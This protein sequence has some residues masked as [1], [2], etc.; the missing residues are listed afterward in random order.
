MTKSL[1]TLL[2]QVIQML[3]TLSLSPGVTLQCWQDHR[4]KQGCISI[5]LVR[6][7]AAEEA[8]MN[9]LLPAVL[10]RGSRNHPDLRS[11][12]FALDDLYGA[13]VSP[14]V[15]RVG[16]RQTTGLFCAFMDQ[17][18][19]LPGDRVL[20]PMAAFLNELL[21][22]P[23]LDNGGFTPDYVESEKKNLISAIEA[24][25]N[26][27]QAYAM[28][29]L[30]K[31]MG[32]A[33][34]FG[35][36]RLGEPAEI[37]AIEPKE[38]YHHYQKILSESPIHLFYAGSAQPEAVAAM[39]GSLFD[40]LDRHPTPLLPQTD[41]HSSESSHTVEALEVTQGKL[42]LGYTTPITNRCPEFAAMQVFNSLFGAGMT[43]KLFL[44]LREEQSL[45]YSIGSGYYSAKGILTVYAGIDQDREQTVRDGIAHQLTLCQQG[46][47]TQEELEAAREAI[48]SGLQSTH[49]SPGAIESYYATA[50]L[51]GLG[52][53]PQQY[54]DA[55]RTVSIPDVAQAARSLVLHSS[56]FLKGVKALD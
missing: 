12:T 35:I 30:L 32:R 20:E 31:A 40:G 44:H 22:Q 48:L 50:A 21:R 42:C 53:T 37:E 1:F 23:V 6:P 17:R 26:D 13:S 4:F 25:M 46:Q 38:L 16:D 2:S 45:C 56:F 27:K 18:F 19:A 39:L 51:S 10:L 33:D 54:A 7:M 52:L 47:I 3:K 34:S 14:L 43:S 29:R 24:E 41:F 55:V 5:Q 28:N 49:D 11:I 8:A 15:R 9:A 36:P